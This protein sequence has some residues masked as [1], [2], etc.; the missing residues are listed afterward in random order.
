MGLFSCCAGPPEPKPVEKPAAARKSV[1]AE[2]RS[3]EAPSVA[4]A[5]PLPAR[6]SRQ[7][8]L[9]GVDVKRPGAAAPALPGLGAALPLVVRAVAE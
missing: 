3:A 2:R 1:Q 6:S 5:L 4:V 9:L 8:S 7:P